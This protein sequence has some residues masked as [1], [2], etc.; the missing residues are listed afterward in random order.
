MSSGAGE[1]AEE[2]LREGKNETGESGGSNKERSRARGR[3]EPGAVRWH[4]KRRSEKR[5]KSEKD[6]RVAK[7]KR[8]RRWVEADESAERT[9]GRGCRGKRGGKAV[10]EKGRETER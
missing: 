6:R 4:K 7:G 1:A 3:D 9:E 8:G 5:K 2:R 10:G